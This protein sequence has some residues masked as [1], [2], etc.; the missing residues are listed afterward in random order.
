MPVL[1]STD[2]D[3]GPHTRGDGA[4]PLVSE[5]DGD[6]Y[7]PLEIPEHGPAELY[8]EDPE[9]EVVY[10]MSRYKAM[11][12]RVS[13][14]EQD[15][16]R[17]DP[18]RYSTSRAPTTDYFKVHSQILWHDIVKAESPLERIKGSDARVYML[19]LTL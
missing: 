9:L 14:E 8:P 15:P 13:Y 17:E 1:G 6:P 5:E 4:V 18:S 2:E 19:R 16:G 10:I 7:A 12:G 11:L 3:G